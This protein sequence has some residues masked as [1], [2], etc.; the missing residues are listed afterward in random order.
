[1]TPLILASS[2]PARAAMLRAA[3]VR[4]EVLPARVDEETVKAA[5][6]A[7]GAPPRDVADALAAMK[8]AR[9]SARAPGALT[10]G[11]DQTLDCEG[12]R[13]DKPADREAARAQLLALRGRPHVLH[14]AAAVALDGAVIWRHVGR[15][16]MTMRPFGEAF[17]DDYLAAEGDA[18]PSGLYRVE[19]RGAQLFAQIEGDPFTILGLPLLALMGFLRARGILPE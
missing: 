10:L 8:A 11:A 1:M 7:E 4:F 15:A 12:R 14:S 3:G 6:D 17:L 18:A 5:L 13:F 9:G 2:S 16:R 19:G